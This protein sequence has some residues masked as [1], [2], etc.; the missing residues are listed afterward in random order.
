MVVLTTSRSFFALAGNRIYPEVFSHLS[1]RTHEP[2]YA[3]LRREVDEAAASARGQQTY[4]E[5]AGDGTMPGVFGVHAV[6]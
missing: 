6:C 5:R 4:A 3:L 2:H 1:P